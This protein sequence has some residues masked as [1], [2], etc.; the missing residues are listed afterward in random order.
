M[1]EIIELTSDPVSHLV[2]RSVLSDPI[3]SGQPNNPGISN[4]S[5]VTICDQISYMSKVVAHINYISHKLHLVAGK[6][7]SH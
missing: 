1:C 5:P 6:N 7:V 4:N 3:T 2:L